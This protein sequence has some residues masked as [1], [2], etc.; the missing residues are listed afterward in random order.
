MLLLMNNW[1]LKV[2]DPVSHLAIRNCNNDIFNY[3]LL[4][5]LYK[6][7][8]QSK[9]FLF[10]CNVVETDFLLKCF[11]WLVGG[12]FF[13]FV[14]IRLDFKDKETQHSVMQCLQCV[15]LIFFLS[16]HHSLKKYR[17]LLYTL[18]TC[19]DL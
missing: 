10:L 16:Q 8:V 19:W 3:A 13:F 12:L 18:L 11:V 14:F 1:R 15:L 4:S 9:S 17:L 6:S 2:I 5:F 7:Q